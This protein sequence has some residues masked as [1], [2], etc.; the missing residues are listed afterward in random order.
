MS[1]KL[2]RIA[3]FV[4]VAAQASAAVAILTLAPDGPVAMHFSLDGGV[5]RWGTRNEAA[6]L[7]GSMALLSAATL[8]VCP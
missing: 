1:K 6:V 3:G 8:V 2:D 5:D 7:T 4:L